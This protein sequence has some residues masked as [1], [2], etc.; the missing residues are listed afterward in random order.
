LFILCAQLKNATGTVVMEQYI[1]NITK[2]C[3]FAVLDVQLRRL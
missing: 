2:R 3:I 1:T